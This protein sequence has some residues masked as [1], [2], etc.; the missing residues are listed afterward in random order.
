MNQIIWM[1]GAAMLAANAPLSAAD[2]SDNPKLP[3]SPYVVHD[4]SRPQP[5]VVESGGALN[6]K[7][8]ADATVLFEGRNLDA[9]T[10]PFEVKDGVMVAAEGDLRSKEEFGAVQMHFE[11][12]V[13][14]GRK[15]NGQSG[16]N[17]GVFLM[18][19]YEVQVLQSNNNETYPDGQAGSLYGQRPPLVNVTSPQGEWNSYD[20]IFTPP[21]YEGEEVTEP[22]RLTLLHNG[23]LV[24]NAQAYLGPTA[25]K[26]VASYP[27]QHPETGPLRIQFHGD[28]IE[29]RNIWIRPIGEIDQED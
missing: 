11:W 25:H 2:Y 23:V 10:G 1:T 28:P 17:S 20:L 5:K 16:G 12:R 7:A 26:K 15:V 29:F 8:P 27:K 4:M 6:T 18:D 13:P 14:A 19:R 21:V 9:W 24:Q 22:A 3:D